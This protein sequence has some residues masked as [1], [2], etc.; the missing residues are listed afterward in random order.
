MKI[1]LK[2]S[3]NNYRTREEF[4]K[5]SQDAA[6]VCYSEK[7]WDEIIEE[8]PNPDLTN[9][10]K[11]GGHHSPYEHIWLNFYITAPKAFVM[12]LNNE[13]QYVTSEKSA[14]YTQMKDVLPEQK[15]KY[16][17]WMEIFIPLIDKVY[18][19]LNDN[20]ERSNGIKKLAQENARYMTSVFTPTKMLHTI[21]LRQL[22]FFIYEFE[23][24]IFENQNGN[25]FNKRLSQNMEEFLEQTKEFRIE[26]LKN[27]TDRHLSFFGKPVEEKFGD[28]YSTNYLMSFAG[29][30][31]AQRHRTIEY[32]ISKKID[33]GAAEGFFIPEIIS[34]D[35]ELLHEW[36]KDL[37]HISRED[38]PQAQLLLVSEMGSLRNFR[39][40]MI[41][42]LC[43]HAQYEIMR[44]TLGTA[45]E[46]SK[47]RPEIKEWM[48]PKCSQRMKCAGGCVWKSGMALERVI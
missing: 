15:E 20:N 29:L 45:E 9:R 11:K 42:R 37:E 33:L 8:P 47:A 27:Q 31:Q 19:A 28:K 41:L 46:Y 4:L 36:H 6:R 22:N 30:A 43:G 13:K 2:G 12:V 7:D 21:N 23:R 14:R 18:P 40:K 26:D 48:K 5:F 32:H 17:K 10:I 3:T 24:F 25:E 35:K 16:D 39:S 44:N 1:E 34:S 38:F